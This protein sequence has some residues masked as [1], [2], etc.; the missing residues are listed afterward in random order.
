M[1]CGKCY[2]GDKYLIKNEQDS[3]ENLKRYWR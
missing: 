2:N 1:D 3:Q